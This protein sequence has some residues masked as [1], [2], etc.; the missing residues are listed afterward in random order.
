MGTIR[1][2][3]GYA[4]L[5]AAHTAC[6]CLLAA[7]FV[8]VSALALA[9]EA[10]QAP[11][12]KA[13]QSPGFLATATRWLGEQV[14]LINSGFKD[15]RRGVENFSREAG[16]AAKTT[17]DGAKDAADAVARIPNARV[18]TGHEKCRLASNGAPDCIAAANDVCK[19][20]GFSSGKSVDMTTAEI[21]PPKA[22]MQ[23]RSN[24]A[25]C[26]TETFVSRAL[27]Q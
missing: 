21:C 20:R 25:A 22:Y 8:M 24:D 1:L 23:G 13:E 19:M 26:V 10:A 11:S 27:C 18:V 4:K 7:A 15:A 16:L 2:S 6:A 5:P 3:T 14:E 12:A 9:Q 17:A